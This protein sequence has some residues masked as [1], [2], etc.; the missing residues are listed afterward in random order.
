M[1]AIS[2]QMA[3]LLEDYRPLM[4]FIGTYT[5]RQRSGG[6]VCDFVFGNPNEMPVQGFAEA[7]ARWSEPRDPH[8]YAY[9]TNE[10]K[11]TQ[12]VAATLRELHDAP[13][14]PDDV[15]MTDG[16]FAGL[17]VCFRAILDPGD[18]VLFVSPPWFFYDLLIRA[19]GGTAVPVRAEPPAFDLPV[20]AIA[21]AITERTR[22]VMVNSPHNPTGRIYPPEQLEA[23]GRVLGEAG[24]RHGRPVYLISDEAYCRIVFDGREFPTPTAHH[25]NSFLVYTYGKT[26]LTPGSRLGYV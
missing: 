25:P 10:P 26:L 1:Q 7:L 3:E 9:K 22:A 6:E 23:L 18:E 13:F 17:G 20:S 15:F 8:W 19:A 2:R 16:A 11:A 24:D 21:A 5:G 4:D 12:A 14:S